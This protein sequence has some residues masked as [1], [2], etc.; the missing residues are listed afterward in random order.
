MDSSL[1]IILILSL[2]SFCFLIIFLIFRTRSNK[3]LLELNECIIQLINKP[4]SS[5][6]ELL[7]RTYFPGL[8]VENFVTFIRYSGTFISSFSSSK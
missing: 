2:L 3:N 6:F 5:D 1:I 8:D 7:N 4:N